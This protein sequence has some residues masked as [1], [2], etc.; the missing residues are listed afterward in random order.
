MIESYVTHRHR[1]LWLIGAFTLLGVACTEVAVNEPPMHSVPYDL[2]PLMES[3]GKSDGLSDRFDSAWL[4][5]DL[6]FLNTSA[7]SV[8]DLQHFLEESPYGGRSWLADFKVD[9]VA[10]SELIVKVA[11]ERGVNPLLLLTRMQVEQSL[12]SRSEPP[13]RRLQDAA[14]GCGCHDGERCAPRFKGFEA[15]LFCA[16]ATLR[17][18]F[19]DSRRGEGL[20][21]AGRSRTT[22][23][24][25]KIRPA[26]H[27]TAAMYAYTPWVLTGRGGNWLAWNIMRKFT[28]FLKERGMIGQLVDFD[29]AASEALSGSPHQDRGAEDLS[30]CLYRSGRAFVGDPCG[31]QRDCDFWSGSQQGFCHSAGFCAL[32]CEG[33]CPDVLDKAQ[34]FCI[35]D[36][37]Q[38]GT[39][40]CVAKASEQNGHCADLPLTIDDERE[41]FIGDSGSTARSA[42]VCV[43][44]SR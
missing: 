38:L 40:I 14:L 37:D 7:L 27:A 34:T 32:P 12:V 21:V 35:E 3:D 5:S 19:D 1:R 20:W 33:G 11:H 36:T 28:R 44:H 25:I 10:A 31:C 13:A 9:Q 23:D 22:L 26:N 17:D 30:Q 4:M 15:Q 16:A 6:F 18:L 8:S 43:P 29:L 41:R 42:E 39:G 24:P 2:E